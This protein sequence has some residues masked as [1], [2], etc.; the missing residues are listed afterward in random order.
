M[1]RITRMTTKIFKL[2]SK[3]EK[4]ENKISELEQKVSKLKQIIAECDERFQIKAINSY[5]K[6]ELENKNKKTSIKKK[7]AE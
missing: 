6:D 5:K 4:L 7:N 3:I 2:K 1:E